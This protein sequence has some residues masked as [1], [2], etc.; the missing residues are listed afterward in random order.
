MFQF[1]RDFTS[2]YAGHRSTEESRRL[3]PELKTFK[4]WLGE[5][6]ARIPLAE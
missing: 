5:N 4:Q 6:A 2:V 3:N 1:K